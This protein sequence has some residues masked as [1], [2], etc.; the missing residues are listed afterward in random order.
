MNNNR[1]LTEHQSGNKKLHSCKTLNVMTTDKVLEAMDSKKLTLVVR[2]DLSKAFDSIDH[3]RLLS[4]LQALGIGRTALEWFRSYLTGRQQYVRIGFET[5]NI[6]PIT[7]GVPQGLILV[8]ALFNLYIN[9]LPTIPESDSLESFVDDS[10]LYLS[11]TVKDATVVLQLINEDLA[12]IATWC[13]YNGL[14]INPDKTKLLVMRNRQMLLRLPK[15]FHVTLLGKEVTPSNS[16]RDLGIEMDVMLSFDEH[17]TNTVSSCFASLCQINRIK[18]LFDSKSLENVI[19][20]LV[21]SQLFYC[22][23]VWSSTSKKNVS[24]LQSV[25]NFAA[26]VVTGSRKFEHITP[27]LRDL[28]WLTVSSMLKYTV[29]ILRFKCVDGLAPRYLCSR[30]VTKTTVHDQNTRNK[31]KFDIL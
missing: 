1:C 15:D 27:V 4:K 7:H 31:N 26:R 9:D 18:H 12:K 3:C 6:S 22:S 17:I 23:P 16:V 14:L 20:A 11:F 5:S 10:K 8:L 28:N 29:A 13:F 21:F 25:Q 2:L 30:F 19:H 24:K